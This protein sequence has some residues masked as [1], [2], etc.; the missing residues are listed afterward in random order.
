[1]HNEAG[2]TRPVYVQL[3][4]S[5]NRLLQCSDGM[6]TLGIN[7]I[8]SSKMCSFKLSGY[9]KQNNFFICRQHVQYFDHLVPCYFKL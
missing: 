7:T 5:R 4:G 8:Y 9:K 1:M 2:L 3:V 6:I